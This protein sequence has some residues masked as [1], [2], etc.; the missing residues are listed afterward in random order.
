MTKHRTNLSIDAQVLKDAKAQGINLSQAAEAG[1]RKEV[2]AALEAQWKEENRDWIDAHNRR[3]E[4][5][6]LAIEPYW[7]KGD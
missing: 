2:K 1:I 5:E 4:R 3:I 7:L 6:G